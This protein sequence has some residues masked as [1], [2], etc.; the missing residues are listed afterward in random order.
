MGAISFVG[1]MGSGLIGTDPFEEN[2]WSGSSKYFFRECD[3]R[4]ILARAFGVE[5]ANQIRIPLMLRNFSFDRELWRQRFYLDTSYYR[6]LGLEIVRNL[7]ESERCGSVLQIGGIYDLKPLLSPGSTVF[8]YHDGN[9]AQALRSPVF[10]KGLSKSA[11]DKALAFEHRVYS[12]LDHIFTMSE[13]LR[14]SFIDDFGVPERK[15][16]AIGAGV[17][18][19]EIPTTSEK[20]YAS[21]AI[22]FVGSDFERKGGMQ[23]LQAFRIVRQRHGDASLHVIGPRALEIPT[24]VAEGVTYHGFLSRR[25]AGQGETFEA[26]MRR[27]CLFVLPSLY[28]PF[29]IAPLEAMLYEIPC[30]L[31]DAWAFPEMVSPGVNG[32]LVEPGSVDQLAET[33]S[34]LLDDPDKMKAMGQA[35]RRRVLDCYT[36]GSVVERLARILS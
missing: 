29:G 18:L 8:S 35:A 17:N 28:E 3:R 19:D 6:Q 14:Q 2:A 13:Y 33:I 30:V 5:V 22:V 20:N 1:V 25:D 12:N 36:W 10:P 34:E 7:S 32:A 16:H 26:V 15:V 27:A 31:S 11:I 4:G 9:L 23:L 24:E 21:K